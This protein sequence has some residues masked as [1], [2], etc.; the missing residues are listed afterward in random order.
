L[1]FFDSYYSLSE[2]VLEEEVEWKNWRQLGQ[3]NLPSDLE[4]TSL[5]LE[6]AQ[7]SLLAAVVV[8]VLRLLVLV[9]DCCSPSSS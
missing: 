8:V 6:L 7:K 5:P 2:V 4:Q 1:L 3:K 9:F